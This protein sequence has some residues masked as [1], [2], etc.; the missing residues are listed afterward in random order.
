LKIIGITGSFKTGKTTALNIFRKLG[1][2]IINADEIAHECFLRQEVLLAIKR[3]FQASDNIVEND[4]INRRRLAEIVFNNGDELKWLNSLIHPLVIQEIEKR[5]ENISKKNQQALVAIEIPL[6][7]EADMEYL[8]DE[9]IILSAK[10]EI[11]IKRALKEGFTR[12]DALN[13][14]ESQFDLLKKE[15]CGDFVI[16]N[17]G[18]MENTR[19][20]I[21]DILKSINEN[22]NR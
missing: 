2:E 16:D 19:Q 22:K 7:Y 4:V 20:Q 17:N 5:L 9:V 10:K 15:E 21:I 6:L 14:I 18:S 11:Q 8:V 12:E 1:A 13:R 3:H